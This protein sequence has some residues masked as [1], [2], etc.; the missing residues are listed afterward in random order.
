MNPEPE[1]MKGIV[2][3][4]AF[5]LT[6]LL[7]LCGV[8]ACIHKEGKPGG[9]EPENDPQALFVLHISPVNTRADAST[10][11]VAEKI[12]SL[13]VIAISKDDEEGKNSV[14]EINRKVTFDNVVA[15]EKFGY[16]LTWQTRP[17]KKDFYI[18]ANE[19]SVD[20]IHVT[21]DATLP[22]GL[23][24]N[25]TLTALLDY[26]KATPAGTLTENGPSTGSHVDNTSSPTD[27]EAAKAQATAFSQVINAVYFAPT[28]EIQ[29]NEGKRTVYLPYTTFYG[30]VD[31]KKI[32]KEEQ[33]DDVNRT[34]DDTPYPMFLVP[35]ATKFTFHFHNYRT[36]NVEIQKIEVSST[37]TEN[38]LL[39]QVAQ[40]EQKKTFEDNSYYWVDWLEK[41]SNASWET[42]GSEGENITFNEKYGWISDYAMPNPDNK[43][44]SCLVPLSAQPEQ[45]APSLPVIPAGKKDESTDEIQPKDY[46]LGPF[47]VPESRNLVAGTTAEQQYNLTLQLQDVSQK[48]N[49]KEFNLSID[50]LKALFRNTSV[51]IDITLR[52]GEVGVYAEIVPWNVKSANGWLIEGD[53]PNG[54]LFSAQNK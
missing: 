42:E 17:G 25:P 20:A 54:N 45:T 4:I 48:D 34:A 16:S 38:F 50:N 18:F 28:Y 3:H 9:E 53:A 36:N 43:P 47:Y 27:L 13:R 29:E 22:G 51:I 32:E 19:E 39:A 23:G 33:E 10:D 30:N 44:P 21:T 37:H 12:Q 46:S 52:E 2:R 15:V 5:L 40:E 26:Y 49:V 31:V 35:V 14:I 6:A 7:A 1:A 8:S 11:G 41:V 24:T